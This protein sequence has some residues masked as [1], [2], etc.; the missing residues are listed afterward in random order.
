MNAARNHRTL[1]LLVIAVVIIAI[2]VVFGQRFKQLGQGTA[3]ASIRSVQEQEGIPVETVTVRRGELSQWITLAGTVEG[4][5]QYSV[6][7]NNALRVVGLPVKE[8]DRVR[9]GDVIIRLASEAPSPMYHSVDKSRANYQNALV[10]VQRLRNLY[11]AGA[12]AKADLDAAETTVKVLAA[13]LQDAEGSTALTASEAGIVSSILVSEGQTVKTGKAL[14]W[15]TDTSEVKVVF[16]AG[17]NQALALREG[18]PVRWTAPDGEV[19]TG[20]I[21]QLDLMADPDTHLLDGKALFP[22]PDGRL[23]PGLLVSFKVRTHHREDALILPRGCVVQGA[24]GDAVWVAGDAASLTSV[25]LGLRTADQAEVLAG[26]Q[27]GQEVVLHGQTLL[28]EGAKI[29]TV[30]SGEG[31]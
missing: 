29:K 31:R 28:S 22:N 20:T 7:S 23:V 4:T 19:R 21:G 2:A 24:A 5:V 3:L 11:E 8:G 13:D 27:E 16:S 6:V 12:V 26:L 17:G 14:A 15:I 30:G 10:D 25:T 18:Q 1:N 9:K